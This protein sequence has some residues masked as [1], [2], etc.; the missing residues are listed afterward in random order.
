[1]AD[2]LSSFVKDVGA[3]VLAISAVPAEHLQRPL[4]VTGGTRPARREHPRG[5]FVLVRVVR[6]SR[7]YPPT[8]PTTAMTRSAPWD[9]S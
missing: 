2:A 4:V 1:M 5:R 9:P 6:G 8:S 7:R 3:Y